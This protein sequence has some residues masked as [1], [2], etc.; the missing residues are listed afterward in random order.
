M[1]DTDN[2]ALS[3]QVRAMI[4]V[5]GEA[6]K[7][8]GVVDKEYLRR[9]AQA[10]MDPDPRYWDEEFCKTTP[11]GQIIVPPIMVSYFPN[12]VSQSEEDSITTGFQRNA[13]FDGFSG[14]KRAGELPVIP[15]DLV[16]ILNAGNE[17]EIYMYPGI[18]DTVFFQNKYSDIRERIGREGKPFL[19]VTVETTFQNQDSQ[20]LCITRASIIRR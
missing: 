11:Y 15:T 10:V 12:R 13:D 20:V 14:V 18:G 3:P 17:L 2:T 7:C 4:G 16:R 1:T 19:I 6:V 8:L 5:T 9:F